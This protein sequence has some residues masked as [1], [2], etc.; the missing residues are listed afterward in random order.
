M[1]SQSNSHESLLTDSFNHFDKFHKGYLASEDLYP[2]FIHLIF[3]KGLNEL[4][5]QK[6]ANS[7]KGKSRLSLEEIQSVWDS[8]INNCIEDSS[9]IPAQKILSLL[10]F[11]KDMANTKDITKAAVEWAIKEISLGKIYEESIPS[12]SYDTLK[13]AIVNMTELLP[14]VKHQYNPRIYEIS[15]TCMLKYPSEIKQVYDYY[16]KVI[17]EHKE[18][19]DS[20][21][22]SEFN[23]FE[24]MNVV[25]RKRLLP[26]VSYRIFQ[27]NE[28]FST[29]DESTFKNFI[30]NIRDGY[31]QDNPFHNDIHVTDVLQMCHFM[32]NN[33]LKEIL[34]LSQ[35]EI[36]AFL[37]AAICHDF[38]HPGV[39]NSFL[40]N[41]GSVLAMTYND[42]SILENFHIEETFHLLRTESECDIFKKFKP[43]EKNAI[44]KS[45]I[46]CILGT[47]MTKHFDIMTNLQKLIE[48]NSIEDGKNAEKV[49]DKKTP[50]TEFN[51]KQFILTAALH[52]SDISNPA[53]IY[54]SSKQWSMRVLEEFWR[55]G[56][57][58][59][60]MGMAISPL[61]DRT[62]ANIPG[63]QIGFSSGLSSPIFQR[64]VK[65][66]PKFKV[67][68]D[69]CN[70]TEE[71]WKKIQQENIP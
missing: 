37:T 31:S 22:S 41:T 14:W 11:I 36:L 24:V 39:T 68:I 53:R 33:G 4:A 55:Q 52:A 32:V 7:L 49:V 64:L 59:A 9:N 17:K 23:T 67:M 43:E 3:E 57:L 19:M 6:L 12:P 2:F 35:L 56:D 40:Q 63:S 51:S 29:I 18:L 30:V 54:N 60:K 46:I 21:N 42:Q 13:P 28:L 65:I 66:F 34:N 8:Q 47:D 58:E 16:D 70:K 20:V 5:V 45:M 15:K 71:E 1:T 69:F 44:R 25:G 50:V 62:N 10:S 38:R 26:F 48:T 27:E 61:C